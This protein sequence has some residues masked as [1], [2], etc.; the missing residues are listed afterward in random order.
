MAEYLRLKF[1]IF[2][3]QDAND[4]AVINEDD[5]LL[6]IKRLRGKRFGFSR[7][8]R[9][10]T[11]AYVFTPDRGDE[12]KGTTGKGAA[13]KG[14]EAKG[15][16]GKDAKGK[17]A[18][19]KAPSGKGAS[20]RKLSSGQGSIGQRESE[21][22]IRVVDGDKILAEA[23]WKDFAMKGFHNEENLMAAAGLCISIGADPQ[24]A[25]KAAKDFK[26]SDHR[27]EYVA[28]ING[29]D[30]YDDS[31]GTNVGAVITAL[32]NFKDSSVILILG[33]RDKD[34]DFKPLRPHVKLKA[35]RLILLGETKE[36]IRTALRG[37]VSTIT[38]KDMAAAVEAAAR[39]ARPGDTVLLSPACASFD[40]FK[41]YKER[42]EVFQR[43]V[44]EMEAGGKG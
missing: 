17:D 38:V 2:Q 39:S 19:G 26:V 11:G 10:L 18:K 13:G 1:R 33:G 20:V 24:K 8:I 42:G 22:I 43:E 30:Y 25:L 4:V 5:P 7:K 3:N 37:A 40:M 35:R 28:T 34:M 14:T 23:A 6:N 44:K 21:D 15:T 32:A 36:K 16:K 12:G 9:P 41:S 31:K 29:A 27:L